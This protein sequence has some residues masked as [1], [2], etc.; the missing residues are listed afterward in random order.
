VEGTLTEEPLTGSVGCKTVYY[1]YYY[2][3]KPSA[4]IERWVLRFQGCIHP[5]KGK[6]CRFPVKAHTDGR[7]QS[8]TRGDRSRGICQVRGDYRYSESND[9]EGS[10]RS[11]SGG[12]R[13]M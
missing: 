3:S 11:I 1:Y 12:R 9:Y 7:R 5:R 13:D 10:G 4:R 6:C 2:T 8:I